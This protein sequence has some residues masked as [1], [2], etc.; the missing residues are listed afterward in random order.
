MPNSKE[1]RV[2][3]EFLSKMTATP[4]GPSKGPTAERV[5]LQFGG[6]LEHLGLFGRG[7][8]VVAQEVAG[9]AGPPA[10]SRMPGRAATNPSS[11]GSVMI[12]G[13]ASRI[14]L[15]AAALTR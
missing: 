5:L 11:W 15:G 10:A 14:T 1:N 4:R 7:Q 13:G 9:H 2:R 12:S 3:V 8:V 6:Q